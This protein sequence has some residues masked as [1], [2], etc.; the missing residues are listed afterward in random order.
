MAGVRVPLVRPGCCDGDGE[1]VAVRST[2]A[3]ARDRAGRKK[4]GSSLLIRPV[5]L[6]RSLRTGPTNPDSE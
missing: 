6:A 4:L 3:K 1:A 2:S 5:N